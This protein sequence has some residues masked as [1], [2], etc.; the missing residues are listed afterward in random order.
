[1]GIDSMLDKR[2]TLSDEISILEKKMTEQVGVVPSSLPEGEKQLKM[3]SLFQEEVRELK[4]RSSK[5][6]EEMKRGKREGLGSSGDEDAIVGG[7]I[8]EGGAL[9]K[10][11]KK[12]NKKKRKAIEAE[13]E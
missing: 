4:N 11:R 3:L 12:R 8:V 7:I 5:K 10:I 6:I 1:M 9:K 2:V 13:E